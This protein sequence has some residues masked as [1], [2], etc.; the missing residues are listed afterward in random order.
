M[1]GVARVV[2]DVAYGLIRWTAQANSTMS[3]H[4]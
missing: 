2:A 4:D 1:R 3:T